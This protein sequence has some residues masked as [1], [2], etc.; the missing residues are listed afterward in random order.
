MKKL[1]FIPA[2]NVRPTS[3]FRRRVYSE[4]MRGVRPA[5]KPISITIGTMKKLFTKA[6]AASASVL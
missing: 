2:R 5:A 4:P 6:A 1:S 3:M